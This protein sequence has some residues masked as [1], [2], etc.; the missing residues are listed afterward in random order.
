M[1]IKFIKLVD[2]FTVITESKEI[3]E[4]SVFQEFFICN[5]FGC[6]PQEISG[7]KFYSTSDKRKVNVI[8]DNTYEIIDAQNIIAT[9]T[10]PVVKI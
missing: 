2:K 7:L 1:D 8:D 10:K 6:I 3:H 5:T 9:R 4:I